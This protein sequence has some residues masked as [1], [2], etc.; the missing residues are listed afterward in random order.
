MVSD[1]ETY[2]S[3]PD[4]Q[5]HVHIQGV[6]AK[7]LKRYDHAVVK[8][9][10]LFH[11]LGKL[12][13][14]FQE[15]LKPNSEGHVGYDEHAYL[16]AY[17]WLCFL[18]KNIQQVKSDFDGNIVL[19]QIVLTLIAK[20]HGDLPDFG[21]LLS[22][23]PHER[24]KSFLATNPLLPASVYLSQKLGVTHAPF[25][26]REQENFK[27]LIVFSKKDEWRQ[28]ALDYYLTAQ[29]AFA[30]LI[31]ADKRDAGVGQDYYHLESANALCIKEL[32]A[33]LQ[34]TWRN[35][36]GKKEKSHLDELRTA[37]REEAVYALKQQLDNGQRIFTLTAPTGAGK[38]YTLLALAAEIQKHHPDQSIL[39]ALP[40]LSITEQVEGIAS[41]LVSDVLPVNS[42][43]HN[44]QMERLIDK[45][46]CNP[47]PQDYRELLKQDFTQQ[48]F[49]HP[50]IITTFVQF[51]ETLLS[52][53]N[54]TLLKLPNFSKRIFLI[55]EIQALPPRLYIFFA[56]WLEACCRRWDS[57]AILST[58][59]M[60]KM[61]FILKDYVEETKKPEKLFKDYL[62]HLPQELS[63]PSFYFE[64]DVF[65]RYEIKLPESFELN[66]ET[67][68]ELV[69]NQEQSCLA[70]VNT[71]RD[72]RELF[73]LLSEIQ[74]NVFL[75]NT[76][77]TP[78]D[79]RKKIALVKQKLEQGRKVILVSTQL[80]E[81]GVDIDFP[82][83]FRDLCPLP[84]LI[85][86]AGRCN[87]NKKLPHLGTVWFFHLVREN[88]RSGAQSVYQ[89]EAGQFLHFVSSRI[90]DGLQEKDLFHVQQ[91]FFRWIADKLMIG[92]YA[93]DKQAMNLIDLVNQAA[94]ATLG[95]FRLINEKD[96]GHEY[97]YYIPEEHKNDYE[98]AEN[99]LE[100]LLSA[101][102]YEEKKA[103][104]IALNNQLKKVAE[105]TITIRVFEKKDAPLPSNPEE[106]FGIRVL[107]DTSLYSFERGLI[108]GGSTDVIL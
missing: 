104:K 71:I 35:L 52:N 70:I 3:H 67:L 75:L 79:R 5:L 2:Q 32:A 98:T 19:L 27:R 103:R 14:N 84:S 76:H 36:D 42:K 87:R 94:F 82:V 25:A 108:F 81:A 96:F 12:N 53:R 11:D 63:N 106:H 105:R 26:V 34:Q 56:A 41:T 60:P 69:L 73:D 43:A 107:S 93:I 23:E 46:D 8:W 28:Q 16:S 7:A 78:E 50:L 29:G 90:K 86:S 83:V 39:Y 89:N 1:L 18:E 99:I 33:N 77:F 15:K 13:P 72:S 62:T 30:A 59:T 95:K 64:Q 80:I 44:E 102:G 88:G 97:R 38:T 17:A 10:A 47:Q 74:E 100:R 40:F 61:D 6:T 66:L 68:A 57:Y 48:T 45:L 24:L 65:N 91:D 92:D 9:A 101:S 22:K 58:A 55:D 49:D 37:L 85:Q 54:A 31:E 51:F 4:K 21:Q 20:H